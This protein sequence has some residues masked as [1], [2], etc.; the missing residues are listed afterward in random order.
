VENSRIE[1]IKAFLKDTPQD[2][3]LN[4][5]LAIE[6]IGLDESD[7][8]KS[9]FIQLL[10]WHPDYTATYYHHG[11]LLLKEGKKEDA[12]SIFNIG[13]KKAELQKELHTAAE[14]RSALNEILYDDE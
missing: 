1:Q 5:A 14:L 8:A 13:I 12:I 7:K 9:I 3:F 10:D 11:K 6:Y 4:Y 2:A